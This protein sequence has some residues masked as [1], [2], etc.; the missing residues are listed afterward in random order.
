MSV[1]ELQ[2]MMDIVLNKF[3]VR[4]DFVDISN[5]GIT[6]FLYF[7]DPF[8]FNVISYFGMNDHWSRGNVDGPCFPADF[9]SRLRE[10]YNLIDPFFVKRVNDD[11]ISFVEISQ[12]DCMAIILHHDELFE[13]FCPKRDTFYKV[14]ASRVYSHIRT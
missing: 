12:R 3:P 6:F 4:P 10:R 9:A 1:L 2:L 13:D 8:T 7:R 14:E 5:L 11:G